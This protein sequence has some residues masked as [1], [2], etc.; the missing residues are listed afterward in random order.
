MLCKQCQTIFPN[1]Y[2]ECPNCKSLDFE[3]ERFVV[4]HKEPEIIEEVSP[5]VECGEVKGDEL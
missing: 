5:Y 4:A 2:K 1:Y 3:R